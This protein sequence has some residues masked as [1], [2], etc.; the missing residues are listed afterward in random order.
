M[1]KQEGKDNRRFFSRNGH[2]MPVEQAVISLFDINYAYGYGVYETLRI[3]QGVIFFITEHCQR[4]LNSARHIGLEHAYT[5]QAIETNIRQLVAANQLTSANV[6]V[7]LIGDSTAHTDPQCTLYILPMNPLYPRRDLYKHG[8]TAIIAHGERRYPQ[9]KTLDMLLSAV[10][11]RQ[12]RAA[13]AYDA[14]L[15]NRH[16][17]VVEGTRSS[18][19]VTDGHAIYTPP[20]AETLSGVTQSIILK[21]ISTLGIECHEQALP[22]SLFDRWEGIFLTSTS[23]KVMPITTVDDIHFDIPPIVR[24]LSTEYTAYLNE[25]LTRHT[26]E[27]ING[28]E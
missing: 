25:Y 28:M 4:L 20:S 23:A 10:A 16:E 6:K 3:K 21:I 8:A 11:Y 18:L 19:F 22:L 1:D 2:I 27:R 26:D 24:A 17:E 12:A 13:K 9:A 7:M 5:A 14:L 15:V